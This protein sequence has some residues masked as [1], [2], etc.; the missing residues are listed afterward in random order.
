MDTKPHTQKFKE[1]TH[2]WND[3]NIKFNSV[4]VRGFLRTILAT[5]VVSIMPRSWSK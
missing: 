4:F 2:N 5:L 1:V 3:K